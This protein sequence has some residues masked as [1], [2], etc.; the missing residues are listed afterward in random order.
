MKIWNFLAFRR[1]VRFL[2]TVPFSI[3]SNWNRKISILMI[4]REWGNE[5]FLVVN[6]LNGLR[7]RSFYINLPKFFPPTSL[8]RR[9]CANNKKSNN[10]HACSK[11]L[12]RWKDKF[13]AIKSRREARMVESWPPIVYKVAVS[14]KV[15]KE[16]LAPGWLRDSGSLIKAWSCSDKEECFTARFKVSRESNTRSRETEERSGVE[17]QG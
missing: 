8:S 1:I 13:G 14:P 17:K 3:G 16:S 7:F 5:L 11:H 6:S 4:D 2:E 10:N 9:F 12:T 15:W